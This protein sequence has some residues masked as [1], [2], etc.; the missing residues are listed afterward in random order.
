MQGGRREERG[1]EENSTT[2]IRPDEEEGLDGREE[3][4]LQAPTPVV[5]LLDDS[6]APQ[7]SPDFVYLSPDEEERRRALLFGESEAEKEEQT[8]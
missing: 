5:T 7:N 4:P 1:K 6:P 8:Q 2:A 3:H